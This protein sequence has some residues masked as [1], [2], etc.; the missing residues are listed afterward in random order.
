MGETAPAPVAAP[1]ATGLRILLAEDNLVNQKVAARLLERLGHTCQIVDNGVT[2]LERWRAGV[3]DVLL[4]DLQMQ[5]WTVKPP[6]ACFARR[7]AP[8]PDRLSLP[9]P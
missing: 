8:G 1:G 4:I 5:R 2:L 6:F 3:W 7:N 9:S